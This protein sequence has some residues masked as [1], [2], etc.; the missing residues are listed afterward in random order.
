MAEKFKPIQ[1]DYRESHVNR[2]GE[3]DSA[4]SASSFDS[5]MTRWEERHVQ[6]LLESYYPSGVDRYLDFAC[7]TGRMTRAIADRCREVVGVDVSPTM[8][9]AARPKL[10]QAR[11]VLADLTSETVE[12]GEFDL[13]SSFRFFGNAEPDLRAAA[14]RALNPLVRTGGH[15]LVNNHRNPWALAS[16]FHRL[17]GGTTDM[18]LTPRIFKRIL[19]DAGFE[20]VAIRPI[21][22]W[23]YRARLAAR[24]GRR[25]EREARLEQRFSSSLWAPIAPDAVILARKVRSHV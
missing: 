9:N 3:Y 21:A 18:H 24:A 1:G 6:Q 20:I 2:G 8:L 14:L 23:Q 15:L 10:P 22:V 19:A 7:G 4:L 17:T 16:V 11:F 25:P 13:V 12:L 5:Y